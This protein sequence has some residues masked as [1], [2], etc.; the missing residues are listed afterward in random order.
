M[1]DNMAEILT[2]GLNGRKAVF[3]KYNNE[4]SK[5]VVEQVLGEHFSQ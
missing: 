4:T 1:I 5:K 3:S 2:M